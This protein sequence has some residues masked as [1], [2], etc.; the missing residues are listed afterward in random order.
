MNKNLNRQ[1]SLPKPRK[2]ITPDLSP[3]N[4][5]LN[6]EVGSID[7][8]SRSD[9]KNNK[10]QV[11]L[12]YWIN[13]KNAVRNKIGS[14]WNPKKKL[15]RGAMV[16]MKDLNRFDNKQ[17]NVRTLSEKF[18]VSPESVRRILKSN[19]KPSDLKSFKQNERAK[20]LIEERRQS[21][22]DRRNEPSLRNSDDRNNNLNLNDKLKLE[23]DKLKDYINKYHR[24]SSNNYNDDDI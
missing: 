1:L 3:V 20:Q 10:N 6:G 9:D 15:S 21:Y 7:K 19:F 23:N 18:K 8:D 22:F 24:R 16:G 12:N 2:W 4:F 13:H 14:N 5:V 11:N 17:F